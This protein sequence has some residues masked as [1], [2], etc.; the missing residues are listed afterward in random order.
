MSERKIRKIDREGIAHVL[1]QLSR[2]PDMPN[3]RFG[4]ECADY[5]AREMRLV[6]EQIKDRATLTRDEMMQLAVDVQKQLNKELYLHG[7]KGTDEALQ[8][9]EA[10]IADK[11]DRSA[12]AAFLEQEGYAFK[13]DD[14]A[15]KYFIDNQAYAKDRDMLVRAFM[16]TTQSPHPVEEVQQLELMCKSAAIFEGLLKVATAFDNA[17]APTVEASQQSLV[18]K[19]HERSD[20][21]MTRKSH[22]AFEEKL[23]EM[24]MLYYDTVGEALISNPHPTAMDFAYMRSHGKQAAAYHLFKQYM[25]DDDID[26]AAGH[27]ADV[28]FDS[29]YEKFLTRN[30]IV[31]DGIINEDKYFKHKEKLDF[32]FRHYAAQRDFNADT[33]IENFEFSIQLAAL[34]RANAQLAEMHAE[35]VQS[36]GAHGS[37]VGVFSPQQLTALSKALE[38]QALWQP[39]SEFEHRVTAPAQQFLKQW[40]QLLGAWEQEM[41]LR[42]F[43]RLMVQWKNAILT[44]MLGLSEDATLQEI[45]EERDLLT[46]HAA[47]SDYYTFLSLQHALDEKGKV[48]VGNYCQLRDQH[49]ELFKDYALIHGI[50]NPDAQVAQFEKYLEVVTLNGIE[51]HIENAANRLL[52]TTRGLYNVQRDPSNPRETGPLGYYSLN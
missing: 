26:N 23:I 7:G 50:H 30:H 41:P 44:D 14:D 27:F 34:M 52:P 42:D 31:Q 46:E 18:Y 19:F 33:Q 32:E 15:N 3:T 35:H 5:T 11:V 13:D 39:R 4:R 43:D 22:C 17:A 25:S 12:Y 6:A 21:V 45:H 29:E 28:T 9:A 49:L 2:P 1:A 47:R 38:M 36:V 16:E 24:L 48:D 37:R 10:R 20:A 40:R 8:D 51:E